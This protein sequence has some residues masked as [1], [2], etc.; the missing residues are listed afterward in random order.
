MTLVEQLKDIHRRCMHVQHPNGM[1]IYA[2]LFH[3]LMPL[4]EEHKPFANACD[5]I[6]S[7]GTVRRCL[8][9]ESYRLLWLNNP[10]PV[11][12]GSAKTDVGKV[13]EELMNIAK[14]LPK[15]DKSALR[16]GRPYKLKFDRAGSAF[17]FGEKL[18]EIP[19]NSKMARLCQKVL[20]D[21]V[22]IGE[23][24]SWDEI[25]EYVYDVHSTDNDDW[26]KLD[27]LV[28]RLNKKL[29]TQGLPE[30]L[31]FGGGR[32]GKVTRVQ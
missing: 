21:D 26:R 9:D 2:I 28:R 6:E 22:E 5:K 7:F 8:K 4:I 1:E 24:F 31:K 17:H 14:K 3:E 11:F 25:Y 27:L 30:C 10:D 13:C 18:C 29:D 32:G 15:T 12:L 23:D 16:V 20:N 19:R